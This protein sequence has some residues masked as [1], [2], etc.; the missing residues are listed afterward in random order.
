MDSKYSKL[1]LACFLAIFNM[2]F[3]YARIY[4][5]LEELPTSIFIVV[6]FCTTIYLCID[7]VLWSMLSPSTKNSISCQK[8]LRW[9][10]YIKGDHH[11]EALPWL[12]RPLFCTLPVHPLRLQTLFREQAEIYDMT[13]RWSFTSQSTTDLNIKMIISSHQIKIRLND[14]IYLNERA[15]RAKVD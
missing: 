3:F 2:K 7:K 14:L 13:Q 15:K 8:Q 9:H 4:G 12:Y 6:F 11:I 5:R 1:F 10:I